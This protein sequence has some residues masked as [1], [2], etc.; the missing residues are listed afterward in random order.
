MAVAVGYRAGQGWTSEGWWNFYPRT[1]QRIL[2]GGLTDRYYYVLAKDLD[3]GGS[4]G[5]D[6]GFCTSTKTFTIVGNK[7]C[8]FRGYRESKFMKVDVGKETG[9]TVFLHLKDRHR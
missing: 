8:F 2:I 9:W 3:A 4:W 6:L 5:N 7:S 1:C